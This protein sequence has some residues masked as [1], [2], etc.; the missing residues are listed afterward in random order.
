MSKEPSIKTCKA[1][2]NGLEEYGLTIEILETEKWAKNSGYYNNISVAERALNENHKIRDG[3]DF[4][5]HCVC[6]QRLT[7]F[8][9]I[10]DIHTERVLIIG[11]VCITHFMRDI[12]KYFDC[13]K[14]N[15]RCIDTLKN[16]TNNFFCDDCQIINKIDASNNKLKPEIQIAPISKKC[17]DCKTNIDNKYNKCYNCNMKKP[18]IAPININSKKCS[19]CKTTIADKYTKCYKCY[20]QK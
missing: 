19:D 2:N 7:N 18:I 12:D 15:K 11:N 9:I 10:E 14:C 6:G 20:I 1:F 16:K 17:S 5:Y 3:S 4:V 13:Q 8:C